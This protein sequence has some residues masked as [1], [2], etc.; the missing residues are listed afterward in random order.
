MKLTTLIF[1]VDGTLAE[2]EEAHRCSFNQAFQQMGLNWTWSKQLYGDLLAITGGKERIRYFVDNYSPNFNRPDYLSEYI[3]ELHGLKTDIYLKKLSAGCIPLRIGVL[4]LLKEARESKI[5]LAIATTTTYSN[6]TT[7]LEKNLTSNAIKW[8]DVI[9]AGASVVN[10]KPAP[11]VYQFVLKQLDENPQ[12]CIAIE[13]SEN[14]LSSALQAG[15]NTVIT[16][17]EYT[18]NHNFNKA[19]LVVDHLGDKDKPF[20]ATKGFLY[21]NT[22]VDIDLLVHA[23]ESK[24]LAC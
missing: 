2:T 3:V 1:D 8:F 21:A 15:I 7:L 20:T 6:V 10:K 9:A 16:I 4:R 22:Y 24:N 18:Q 13:D 19:V 14:G 17:S 12:S 23:C 5:R 11:D